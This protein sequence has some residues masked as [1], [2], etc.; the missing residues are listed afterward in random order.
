MELN[1]KTL[2][3]QDLSWL[4]Q[5][6]VIQAIS[7]T[8]PSRVLDSSVEWTIIETDWQIL[9]KEDECNIIRYGKNILNETF[10]VYFHIYTDN[11]IIIGGDSQDQIANYMATAKLRNPAIIDTKTD[12]TNGARWFSTILKGRNFPRILTSTAPIKKGTDMTVIG[13]EYHLLGGMGCDNDPSIVK[14]TMGYY[15]DLLI[16]VK[17]RLKHKK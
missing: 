10:K 6:E 9:Y 8:F 2:H 1:L 4:T 11:F 3:P 15:S 13:D 12:Y 7:N 17:I 5:D 14:E 16:G